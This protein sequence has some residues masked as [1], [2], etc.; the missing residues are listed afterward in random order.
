MTKTINRIQY[1]D[2]TKGVLMILVVMLHL[3]GVGKSDYKIYPE[4]CWLFMLPCF[5]IVSGY[6]FSCKLPF[7]KFL[8]KKT[9]QLLIPYYIFGLPVIVYNII[10]GYLHGIPYDEVIFASSVHNHPLW[11]IFSLYVMSLLFYTIKRY[12]KRVLFIGI[13]VLV[14]TLLGLYISSLNIIDIKWTNSLEYLIYLWIG[15]LW[16]TNGLELGNSPKFCNLSI[17][18]SISV[19]VFVIIALPFQFSE[20]FHQIALS[21]PIYFIGAITGSILLILLMRE[22]GHLPIINFIGRNTLIIL[23][24]HEYILFVVCRLIGF[25]NPWIQLTISLCIL[26]AIATF[27]N[28]YVPWIIGG[29]QHVKI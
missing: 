1:L 29:E 18:L 21:T 26:I 13:T 25:S 9:R 20:Q 2:L 22:I 24:M 15:N 5:F 17:Y 23:C 10:Y 27:V 8:W 28:S 6:F 4:F 12:I 11:F 3:G 14:L 16:K 7:K 19:A